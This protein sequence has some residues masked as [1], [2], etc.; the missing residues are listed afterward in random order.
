MRVHVILLVLPLFVCQTTGRVGHIRRSVTSLAV[1]NLRSD[2]PPSA[3]S[4]GKI[5]VLIDGDNAESKLLGEYVAEAGRFGKVTVKRIYA[6]WTQPQMKTWKDQLNDN[7]VRPIQK[8]AYTQGKSSTDTALII[9][10]MD[11]LHSKQVDGFCI[12][13][14]DSD[15][16]GLAHRIREEGLFIMGIG[17][18]HT[19]TA[20]VR[21]C[22]S[23]TSAEILEERKPG[24]LEKP[25]T[26]SV[27]ACES[28]TSAEIL[29]ERKPGILEQPD[30]DLNLVKK[31]F[32]IAVNID[33]GRCYF[34]RLSTELR[35][36][37]CTFDHRKLG[38]SSFRKFCEGALLEKVTTHNL[39]HHSASPQ[40]LL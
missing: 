23:F 14:S 21:A 29:E 11:L 5:A 12:V 27:R 18:S 6:D 36:L 34:G 40:L 15:Y 7:A 33:T 25:A 13:S 39:C 19:P 38:Y 4:T 28:F 26:A 31:A 10:A 37:D 17:R 30:F 16:T 35:K 2:S 32:R 22:E 1:D 3:R 9:D 20:F 8:F 24:I